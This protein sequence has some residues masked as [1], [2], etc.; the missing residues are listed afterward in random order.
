MLNWCLIGGL[1]YKFASGPA[2]TIAGTGCIDTILALS[3]VHFNIEGFRSTSLPWAPNQLRS[4]LD[5]ST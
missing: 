3:I 2:Q 5:E 1:Q 4:A